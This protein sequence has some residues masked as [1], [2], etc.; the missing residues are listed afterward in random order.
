MHLNLIIRDGR[1]QLGVVEVQTFQSDLYVA[2]VAFNKP[3]GE[4]GKRVAMPL[5]ASEIEA[6]ITMLQTARK[7]IKKTR[8][9]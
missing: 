2:Q 5:D 8:T 4:A 7:N 6:F 3:G 1:N 9:P